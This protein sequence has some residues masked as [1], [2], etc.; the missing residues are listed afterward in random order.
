[1]AEAAANQGNL[2]LKWS[3]KKPK[4]QLRSRPTSRLSESA[5]FLSKNAE[6]RRRTASTAS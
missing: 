1:M 6:I 4:S 3:A 5:R 2:D